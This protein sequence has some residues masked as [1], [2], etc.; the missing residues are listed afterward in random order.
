MGRRSPEWGWCAL[1]LLTLFV[2]WW[3]LGRLDLSWCRRRGGSW[4]VSVHPF[5][6]S[7]DGTLLEVLADQR[8]EELR[9]GE[10]I[11]R[12]QCGV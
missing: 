7:E 6:R 5:G 11:R 2:L 4:L 1:C 12:L 8:G 3:W 9:L 10:K